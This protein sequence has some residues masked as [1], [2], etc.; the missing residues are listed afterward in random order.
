M[1]FGTVVWFSETYVY[2]FSE[3]FICLRPDTS[4]VICG[5]RKSRENIECPNQ[6]QAR[7]DKRHYR[8]G[9]AVLARV[10]LDIYLTDGHDNVNSGYGATDILDI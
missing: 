5:S 8:L 6:E 4:K 3:Y 9:D 2:F 7:A 10:H 1:P